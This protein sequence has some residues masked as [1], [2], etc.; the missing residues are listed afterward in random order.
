MGIT[1]RLGTI[2]LAIQTDA[3][4][5]VGIGAA[6]SGSYKLEVT[7]TAKVSSTLLVS[8][9]LT[10]AAATFSGTLTANGTIQQ[11]SSQDLGTSAYF[12]ANV[13]NGFRVLNAANTIALLSITNAGAATFSGEVNVTSGLLSISGSGGSPPTSGVG[14]RYVSN[15]LLI[16]GGSSD[17]TFQKNSNASA[18]MMILENGNVLIGTTSDNSA[19]LQVNGAF[20]SSLT[21]ATAWAVYTDCLATSGNPYGNVVSFSNQSPNN[22]A[23]YMYY[24]GDSSGARFVVRGNGGISNYQG[25]DTNL[26]DLRLKKDI[27]PLESYWEKFKAIEIV[28][29]KYIDQTH[30]DYNIG[31]I[32]QQVE[33]V[34]PEFVDVDGWGLDDKINDGTPLKS[35]YTEDLHTATIKVLQEAMT[36]IE[37]LNERLNKAGL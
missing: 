19:K 2:P 26:S 8:G 15:R 16:Y 27:L 30:D 22:S 5:N 14:L 3:S 33:S 6:P 11:N 7:G 34:A 37:E 29:F 9:A 28:K 20:Y 36:K 4:N 17:I 32:A 12:S 1:Q 13:T 31:V 24:G 10:G 35:I 25:N 23:S 18:N 21:A